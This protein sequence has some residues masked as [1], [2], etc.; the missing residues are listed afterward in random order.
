MAPLK[1]TTA[2]LWQPVSHIHHPQGIPRHLLLG[3]LMLQL[4]GLSQQ[5]PQCEPLYLLQ[6][7]PLQQP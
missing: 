1:P 2:L 6:G 7:A 5:P 4:L 3:T